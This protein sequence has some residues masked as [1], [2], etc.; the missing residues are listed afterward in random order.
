MQLYHF[1]TFR[2]NEEVQVAVRECCKYETPDFY[3]PDSH[4]VVTHIKVFCEWLL[5]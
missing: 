2:S 5:K 1:V 3:F 4:R